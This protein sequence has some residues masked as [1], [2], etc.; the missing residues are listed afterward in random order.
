MTTKDIYEMFEKQK[1]LSALTGIKIFPSKIPYYPFQPSLD[2]IDNSK[3]HSK[4]NLH[5]V[6]LAE[7]FGRNKMTIEEFNNYIQLL[8]TI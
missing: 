6:C 4:D 7:N 1:G 8:K 3:P 5:L 2:R